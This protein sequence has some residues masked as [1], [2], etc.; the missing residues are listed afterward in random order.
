M[1]ELK[2]KRL[3]L[4]EWRESDAPVLFGWAGDKEIAK[5]CGFCPHSDVKESET[6]IRHAAVSPDHWIVTLHDGCPVGAVALVEDTERVRTAGTQ[7]EI[8]FWTDKRYR[9]EGYATEACEAALGYGFCDKG[10]DSV[11]CN[12]VGMNDRPMKTAVRLGFEY[13]F[14]ERTRLYDG[15]I[16][17]LVYTVM[18]KENWTYRHRG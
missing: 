10:Y 13:A 15:E 16:T 2:T 14:V 3:I 18:M 6:S 7:A 11:S 17:S 5:A 4:R 1:K 9:G 12:I 8:V